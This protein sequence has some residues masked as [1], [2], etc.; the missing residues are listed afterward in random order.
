M[1]KAS[2]KR[3]AKKMAAKQKPKLVAALD[4]LPKVSDEKRTTILNELLAD[5]GKD[6]SKFSP[7]QRRIID[8]MMRANKG[9]EELGTT[10][11]NLQNQLEQAKANKV[12]AFSRVQT[13]AE[14][15][16]DGC[17]EQEEAGSDVSSAPDQPDPESKGNGV[18]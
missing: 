18:D 6:P 16:V 12:S 14:I 2:K 11:S 13:L 1:T 10:I 8:K 4:E 17:L 3:M 5:H 9:F 15:L 7:Y